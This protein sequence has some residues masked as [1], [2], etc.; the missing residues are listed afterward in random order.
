VIVTLNHALAAHARLV[1]ALCEPACYRHAVSRIEVIE[2]HISTVL[3]TGEFAYKI[4]KPVDLGFLDFTTLERRRR[5]CEDEVRLNRRTAPGIYIDV[6]PIGG[7]LEHP[8]V[9]SGGPALE[10]AVR[11]RQ[12]A[13]HATFDA[14]LRRGALAPAHVDDLASSV[15][16]FHARIAVASPETPHG[17]P[18]QVWAAA[19][20]NFR[21]IAA[22]GGDTAE[23]A[24]LRTW[25]EAEFAGLRG[26]LEERRRGGFVRECHGDLHLRNVAL[27]DG[28]PVTFDCI[29]F[30]DTLRWIDVMSEAAFT[31]MDLL[32]HAEHALAF[33]F[34]NGYL[35]AT[36]DYAGVTLLRFYLVYR[37]LVRAKIAAIRAGQPDL[38]LEARM[39]SRDEL[40]HYLRLAVTLTERGGASLLITSGMS[41][42]GKTTVARALAESLGAIH[43]RSDVERKRLHGLAATARTGA[44]IGAGLYGPAASA[45]TYGR[46]AELARV[47]LP[48][49]FPVIVDAAFLRRP[50]R[51]ALRDVARDVG[52]QF[53]IVACDAPPAALRNRVLARAVAGQDASDA[54]LAVLERQIETRESLAAEELADTIACDTSD[55]DRTAASLDE[56]RA[57]LVR[58]SPIRRLS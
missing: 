43:L 49:R 41:G 48:S 12:F 7:T 25:S 5:C 2:T 1:G 11:M 3:L 15:A 52:A 27:I 14:L 37:A 32:A 16:A 9:G 56:A 10:Y 20:D 30:S 22:H 42:S 57:R 53:L 50:E 36:G 28:R 34:L 17:A 58:R 46:L 54:T 45:A 24:R 19:V 35:E 51:D 44:G 4:K 21:Q 8:V 6:V 40:M 29:E 23:L 13:S 33:R 55:A 39:Q 47:L 38:Q 18:E 26:L 31:V